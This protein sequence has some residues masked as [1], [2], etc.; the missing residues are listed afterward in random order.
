MAEYVAVLVCSLTKLDSWWID[1]ALTITSNPSRS[2]GI[3]GA[4]A[5]WDCRI[6]W[7]F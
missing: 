2:K 1:G 7:N 3:L 5:F 6:L 4:S